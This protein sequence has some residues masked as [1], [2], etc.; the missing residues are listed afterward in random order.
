MQ[1]LKT[2]VPSQKKVIAYE[3]AGVVYEL[4]TMRWMESDQSVLISLR[5]ED[6]HDG[7][8]EGLLRPPILDASS[9]IK[10]FRFT[11]HPSVGKSGLSISKN[12]NVEQ[13]KVTSKLLVD[14]NK[15][16]IQSYVF[17]KFV[18]MP[19]DGHAPIIMPSQDVILVAKPSLMNSI[20][21]SFVCTYSGCTLPDIIQHDH[22][23]I[24]AK[25]FTVHL[26]VTYSNVPPIPYG[27]VLSRGTFSPQLN[28]VPLGEINKGITANQEFYDIQRDVLAGAEQVSVQTIEGVVE[29]EIK[30]LLKELILEFR[31]FPFTQV[32]QYIF[33]IG[34]PLRE[35]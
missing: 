20:I 19:G 13:G 27:V 35:I 32:G 21:Y 30:A 15:D 4:F 6:N 33:P 11:L 26:Y 23:E 18:P 25:E 28:H 10:E 9:S 16:N 5:P 31:S 8:S 14:A 17:T 22:Y 29:G 24:D 3:R 7:L 2:K 34:R 12:L 1:G